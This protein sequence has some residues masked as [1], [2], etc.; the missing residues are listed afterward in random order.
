MDKYE[1]VDLKAKHLKLED[2]EKVLE[3]DV[4][5]NISCIE[6]SFHIEDDLEY[7]DCWVGKMPDKDDTNKEIYWYELVEDGSQSYKYVR[8]ATPIFTRE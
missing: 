7:E 3:S 1:T 2:F 8:A 6:M 5:K 4:L